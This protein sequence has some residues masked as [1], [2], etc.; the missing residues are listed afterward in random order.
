MTMMIA[1][2]LLQTFAPSAMKGRIMSLYTLI[3]AGFT[4]L[5]AFIVTGLATKIGLEV[6]T[7]LAGIGVTF[8][9]IVGVS[10]L[11]GNSILRPKGLNNNHDKQEFLKK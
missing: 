7:M 10:V 3:A 11:K 1:N 4:P 2:T 6:A 9:V 8:T 5:G